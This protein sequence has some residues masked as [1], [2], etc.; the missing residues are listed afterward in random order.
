MADILQDAIRSLGKLLACSTALAESIAELVIFEDN[1]VC[2]EALLITDLVTET[3]SELPLRL[4]FD[5]AHDLQ[6]GAPAT[7]PRTED[8]QLLPKTPTPSLV[9]RLCHEEHEGT[10]LLLHGAK[11]GTPVASDV[12]DAVTGHVHHGHIIAVL[13]TLNVHGT[14]EL[15]KEP[16]H[17]L[18]GAPPLLLRPGEKGD[19]AHVLHDGAGGTLELLAGAT[20]L[21]QG[22]REFVV[23]EGHRVRAPRARL[24]LALV[25][26][27][28]LIT[29]PVV[30]AGHLRLN[31]AQ[32]LELCTASPT[33]AA[34]D[35]QLLKVPVPAA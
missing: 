28:H 8:R 14:L 20:L 1:A 9:T 22:V 19:V 21:A 5:K 3:S 10:P 29:D 33:H 27:H 4:L 23:L 18:L 15:V 2:G 26:V 24:V 7:A 13:P 25:T 32:D 17:V 12:S 11:R 31:S 30:V 16:F 35:R 6:L 34:E